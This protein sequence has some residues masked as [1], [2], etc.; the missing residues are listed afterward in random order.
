MVLTFVGC[1][2]PGVRLSF[3]ERVEISRLRL[4]GLSCRAIGRVLC[5]AHTTIAREVAAD[6]DGGGRYHPRRAHRAARDRGRRPKVLRLAADGDLRR[7]VAGL[8]ARG[9]SP[10]QACGR[11]AREHPGDPRWRV[12]HTTVYNAIYVLGRK[13]INA[14]LDVALRSGRVWPMTRLALSAAGRLDRFEGMVGIAQR[15]AEVADRVVPGH[16]EGDLVEGAGHKSAIVTLVERTSRF[17]ITCPLRSGRTS[18]EV[19]AAIQD[20]LRALPA[21]LRRSLTWDQGS[22]M[23]RWADLRLDPGLEVFFCDPHAPWQR[24]T[25]ENTNRLIREYFPKGSDFRAVTDDQLQ[26]A[27]DLL[28]TRARRIHAYA[29]PAEVLADLIHTT[30]QANRGATTT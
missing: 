22:E 11:L 2:V 5:R 15:P 28:N 30:D 25:N 26:H 27:T 17:L 6:V 8:L 7:E 14:E 29:T 12:S 1:G 24:P 18:P 4:E 16:W 9:H 3:Q 19:I 21:Q 10:M 20:G 23:A 13:R